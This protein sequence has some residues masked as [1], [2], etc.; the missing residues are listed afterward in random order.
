MRRHH[1]KHRKGLGAITTAG[2]IDDVLPS[3]IGMSA[4]LLGTL[5]VRS[6]VPATNTKAI[7][8]AP[9]IGAGLGVLGAGAVAWQMGASK[10]TA[11]AAHAILGGTLLFASERLTASTPEVDAVLA[12]PAS[13]V[14]GMGASAPATAGLRALTAEIR[15]P[16]MQG[17]VMEPL[18]GDFGETV[19]VG[20]G[21][22]GAFNPSAFGRPQSQVG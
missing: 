13:A 7:Y 4:A 5:A 22:R 2:L 3:A 20:G 6:F 21:L 11:T 17:V 9:F 18:R 19:N 10:A 8:F 14:T 15:N 12:M 1:R 16:G